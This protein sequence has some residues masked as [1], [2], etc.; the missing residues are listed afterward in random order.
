MWVILAREVVG[1]S[2]TTVLPGT[3]QLDTRT[4]SL[5]KAMTVSCSDSG[6]R[7]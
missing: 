4:L 6:T 1:R 3:R 5:I 7:T 2:G